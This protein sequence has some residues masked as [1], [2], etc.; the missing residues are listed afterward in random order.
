MN[1]DYF[2][3]KKYTQEELKRLGVKYSVNDS[4]VDELGDYLLCRRYNSTVLDNKIVYKL[5]FSTSF[6]GC[7]MYNY[8]WNVC[9]DKREREIFDQI[10]KIYREDRSKA[11]SK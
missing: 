7:G 4:C 5:P 8:I 10:A 9:Q 2:P 1:K 3:S 6:T 11:I